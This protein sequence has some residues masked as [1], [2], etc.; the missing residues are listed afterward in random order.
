[1]AQVRL[2]QDSEAFD[3]LGAPHLLLH[4]NKI[5]EDPVKVAAQ[6]V[7]G[8]V[9]YT[10]N[11]LG[12]AG[13]E[14]YRPVSH[15]GG[16]DADDDCRPFGRRIVAKAVEDR[17]DQVELTDPRKERRPGLSLRPG[18]PAVRPVSST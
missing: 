7:V 8:G 17:I 6:R 15:A 3:V 16:W 2:G 13:Y 18:Q 4:L 10:G 14:L 5:G 1:M 11:W 12:S 9:T